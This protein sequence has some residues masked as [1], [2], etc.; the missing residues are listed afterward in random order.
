MEIFQQSI[1]NVKKMSITLFFQK[2]KYG[3]IKSERFNPWKLQFIVSLLK[4]IYVAIKQI[5]FFWKNELLWKVY[6]KIGKKWKTSN[7]KSEIRSARNI[8]KLV[9]ICNLEY[10]DLTYY[11]SFNENKSFLKKMYSIKVYQLWKN[12]DDS[13]F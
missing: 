5:F 12:A 13:I 2:L 6:S 10:Q 11:A 3:R 8:I 7:W 1:L 4:W 9:I